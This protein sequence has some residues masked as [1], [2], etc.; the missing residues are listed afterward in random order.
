M[1]RYLQKQLFFTKS[2][3]TSKDDV[4]KMTTSLPTAAQGDYSR[5]ITEDEDIMAASHDVVLRPQQGLM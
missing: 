2:I 5:A 3:G 1:L 4:N